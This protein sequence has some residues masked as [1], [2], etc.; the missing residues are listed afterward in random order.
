MGTPPLYTDENATILII[1][2]NDNPPV[3]N[4]SLPV[5]AE[6]SENEDPGSPVLTVH[7]TDA[8]PYDGDITYD[9]SAGNGEDRFH[10]GEMDVSIQVYFPLFLIGGG[11]AK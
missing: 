9:I 1:D 7:A 4:D 10:I 11:V 5:T 2:V 8:D 3:F 6:I